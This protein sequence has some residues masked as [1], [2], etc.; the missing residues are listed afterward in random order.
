[1]KYDLKWLIIREN[2]ESYTGLKYIYTCKG[3]NVIAIFG[4]AYE[5]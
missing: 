2:D 5:F 1:M 3:I 4:A